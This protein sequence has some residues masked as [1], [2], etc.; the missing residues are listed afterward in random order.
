NLIPRLFVDLYDAAMAGD[1][2][3]VR[4]LHT[5]VIKISTTL[6]TIGRH[7]SAFI[8]GLKCALSCLGIC[9]DVLAEPFQ[10]FESQEREQVRRVLAELNIAPA[11]ERSADLPTT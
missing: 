10:R 3:K 9:E 11:D 6:Y 4:E 5:R 8:K 2:A 1:V 7:G